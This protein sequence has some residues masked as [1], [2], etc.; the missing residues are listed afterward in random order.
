MRKL[1]QK[2]LLL[3]FVM[4]IVALGT[5]VAF[6]NSKVQMLDKAPEELSLCGGLAIASYVSTR[7]RRVTRR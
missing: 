1:G 4:T 6:G 7:N 3:F 2:P 5:N